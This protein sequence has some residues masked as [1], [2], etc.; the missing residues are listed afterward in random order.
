[1][2][3]SKP[4]WL[5]FIARDRWV[6][7]YPNIYHPKNIIPDGWTYIKAHEEV[8]LKQQE[9]YLYS[10]LIKYLFSRQFRLD[11]EA[12]AIA[13]ELISIPDKD[14]R[15]TRFK[16]YCDFLSSSAYFWAAKS[17]EQAKVAISVKILLL[18]GAINL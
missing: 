1:M 11:Q 10:W 16:Q 4:W 18:N 14:T 12:E 15:D 2:Y 3:K 13:A 7:V 9:G 17:S 5:F 8:H 6:T